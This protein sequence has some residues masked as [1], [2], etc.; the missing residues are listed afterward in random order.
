M[1]TEAGVTNAV[2][3]EGEV[4]ETGEI[5][6]QIFYIET[7][8]EKRNCNLGGGTINKNWSSLFLCYTIEK[9]EKSNIKGELYKRR[10]TRDSWR[11]E[12]AR[13]EIPN[14]CTET[15][16]PVENLPMKSTLTQE[17][18]ETKG[19][20]SRRRITRDSWETK[21]ASIEIPIFKHRLPTKI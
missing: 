12:V 7:L 18:A 19:E 15:Q 13:I 20:S 6:P 17:P 16:E 21:M 10:R 1:M 11:L 14:I 4:A 3:E 8:R 5:R 9:E 2:V